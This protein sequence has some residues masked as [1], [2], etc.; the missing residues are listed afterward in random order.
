MRVV[1]LEVLLWWDFG[2]DIRYILDRVEM[3][4]DS[5]LNGYYLTSK[6]KPAA[7]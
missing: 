4:V 6:L 2:R 5:G 1:R 3:P 7:V